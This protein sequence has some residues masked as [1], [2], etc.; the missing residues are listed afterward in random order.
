MP[1]ISNT[2]AKQKLLKQARWVLQKIVE[3]NNNTINKKLNIII[4]FILNNIN[5]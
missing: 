2:D 3:I 4:N 5:Y 1:K